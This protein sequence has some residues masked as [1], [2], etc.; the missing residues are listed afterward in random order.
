MVSL[1][2]GEHST[3]SLM[4][5]MVVRSPSPYNGIIGRPGFRK[6]QAVSSTTHVMLKFLVDEG[7]V[8]LRSNTI[9]PTECHMVAEAQNESPPKEPMV[10]KGIKVAIHPEYPEQTVTKKGRMDLC[11]LLKDNLDIFAWKPA[12]MTSV[13]RSIAKHRLNIREGCQPIRQKRR[14]Q[15][16]DRSKVIQEEV[17]NAVVVRDFYK[18]FYNSLGRVRNRCSSSIGKT[19]GLLSFSRGIAL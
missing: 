7:I 1:G 10:M 12:D 4:N 19:R 13:P 2:G 14:G 16:P 11:N 8:T 18:K 17:T 6:V 3:S 9:I 5:F 15:A